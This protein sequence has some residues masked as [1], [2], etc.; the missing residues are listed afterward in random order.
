[1]QAEAVRL[2]TQATIES[3]ARS[4]GGVCAAYR[5][6]GSSHASFTNASL[7]REGLIEAPDVTVELDES[8]VVDAR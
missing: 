2:I 7:L 4:L 5:M 3:T 1:V 8:A 6:C